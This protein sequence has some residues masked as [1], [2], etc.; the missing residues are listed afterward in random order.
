MLAI[1]GNI[2]LVLTA[3]INIIRLSGQLCSI[4][5]GLEGC[6]EDFAYQGT[7]SVRQQEYSF[8]TSYRSDV[9]LDQYSTCIEAGP[10]LHEIAW[11]N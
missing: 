10:M 2:I 8:N 3:L 7:Q 5:R 9:S 1:P 6:S 11:A 4:V